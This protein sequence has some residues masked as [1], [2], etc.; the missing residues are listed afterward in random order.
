MY[1]IRSYYDSSGEGTQKGCW[2]TSGERSG[3]ET[4]C[5][6]G[7]TKKISGALSVPGDK[8]ISHRAV[9]LAAMAEGKSRIQG[10]LPAEDTLRTVGMMIA[11][12]VDI[13]ESSPTE[14]RI[15]GRGMREF[16][17]PQDIIDAGNSGTTIR[18]SYNFV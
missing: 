2:D 1:A 12:G 13:R 9:M 16:Q 15:D 11:L 14:I 7:K 17:E 3:R 5:S 18:I 10:F 8:S 6:M 4:G